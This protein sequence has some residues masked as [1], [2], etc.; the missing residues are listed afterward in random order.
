VTRG[1]ASVLLAVA[2]AAAPA[3]ADIL[4]RARHGTVFLRAKCRKRER[5][6]DLHG[7]A[8]SPG[9][10]GAVPARVVDAAGNQ[11]GLF[12]DPYNE[13]NYT[14]VVLEVGSQLVLLYVQPSG[15][16]PTSGGFNAAHLAADCSDPPLAYSPLHPLVRQGFRYGDD[17]YYVNDPI[18]LQTPVATEFVPGGGGC[19]GGTLLPNGR[20]CASEMFEESSYGMLTKAFSVGA[21][22]LTPPFHVEP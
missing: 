8:G 20:C 11:V 10:P 16:A 1:F 13:D 6:I 2:L 21:V 17:V 12:A 15:F 22:G 4:C 19:M 14:S 5:P 9:T 18:T 7:P 3:A